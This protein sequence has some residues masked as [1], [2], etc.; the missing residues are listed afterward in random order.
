MTML[1]LFL[2]CQSPYD[3]WTAVFSREGSV[4]KLALVLRTIP[5]ILSNR[6][7]SNP[8][9][10]SFFIGDGLWTGCQVDW[11]VFHM[12]VFPFVNA[13]QYVCFV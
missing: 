2:T 8:I 6:S 5:N 1:Q 4:R 7:D 11:D 12:C 3:Y 13:Y 10:E 9:A